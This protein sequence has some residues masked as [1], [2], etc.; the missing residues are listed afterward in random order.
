MRELLSLRSLEDLM[1]SLLPLHGRHQLL[2]QLS[3]HVAFV[4]VALSVHIGVHVDLRAT[5]LYE[6]EVK[7]SVGNESSLL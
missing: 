2:H 3:A 7:W 6:G 5:N 4:H 1:Q